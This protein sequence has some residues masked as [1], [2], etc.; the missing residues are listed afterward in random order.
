[1]HKSLE[2]YLDALAASLGPLPKRRR[3]EELREMRMHLQSAAALYLEAGNSEEEAARTAVEQF[4]AAPVVGMGLVLAWWREKRLDPFKVCGA[5]I[6][7]LII[8]N[9]LSYSLSFVLSVLE[10][11]IG[12][13]SNLQ[14]FFL[15][16]EAAFVFC[17]NWLTLGLTGAILGVVMPKQAVRGA[18]LG[19]A[20][21]VCIRLAWITSTAFPVEPSQYL[22][23]IIDSSRGLTVVL[24]AGL[25][26]RRRLGRQAQQQ[27][28]SVTRT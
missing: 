2:D 17:L 15:H 8:G 5:A 16:H 27:S 7:T 26:S 22:F 10:Y 1:M 25:V 4:G 13:I 3:E 28:A 6:A 11:P 18:F 20:I 9:I 23:Y 24:C 14:V 21:W 12:N 19:I